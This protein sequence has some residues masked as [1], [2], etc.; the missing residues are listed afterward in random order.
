M[1]EMLRVL[2]GTLASLARDRQALLVENLLLR[3]QLAVTLRSRPRPQLR[4]RDR[5]LWVVARRLCPAWRQ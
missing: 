5:L 4:G 2:I 1:L 3:H